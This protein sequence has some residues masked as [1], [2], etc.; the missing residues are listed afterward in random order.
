MYYQIISN[1][2]T[3]AKVLAHILKKSGV[4]FNDIENENDYFFYTNNTWFEDFY[5]PYLNGNNQITLDEPTE[6][7]LRFFMSNTNWNNKA[8]CNILDLL[9]SK[10][11]SQYMPK[12]TLIVVDYPIEQLNDDL[13]EEISTEEYAQLENLKLNFIESCKDWNIVRVDY[14]RFIDDKAY[15]QS[16]MQSLGLSSNEDVQTIFPHYFNL[17]LSKYAADYQKQTG[18]D[19]F[20]RSEQ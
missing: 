18:M 1:H 16:I 8:S 13:I 4:Y 19:L 15:F 17:T 10:Y 12:G 11:F 7:E 20:K 5:R 6:N 3:Q 14:S 9:I 2:S